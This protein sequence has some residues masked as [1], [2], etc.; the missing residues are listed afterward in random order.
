MTKAVVCEFVL[1]ACMFGIEHHTFLDFIVIAYIFVHQHRYPS[2]TNEVII[3]PSQSLTYFVHFQ[4]IL[5]I[6]IMITTINIQS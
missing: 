6:M 4:Q 3:Y 2:G 1:S 5:I